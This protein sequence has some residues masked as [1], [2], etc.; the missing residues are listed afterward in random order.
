MTTRYD[1]CEESHYVDADAVI[2]AAVLA[3]ASVLSGVTPCD[4][5]SCSASASVPTASL[6]STP[7][8]TPPT[9]LALRRISTSVWRFAAETGC[10]RKSGNC[11]SGG[12]VTKQGIDLNPL[13]NCVSEHS[14]RHLLGCVDRA[15][16]SLDEGR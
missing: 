13:H 7:S 3:G 1:G 6:T 10:E 5:A 8:L 4:S 11:Q 16:V 9:T 14:R 15:R 2:G 12:S